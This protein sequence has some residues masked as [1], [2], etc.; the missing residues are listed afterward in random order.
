MSFNGE[1]LKIHTKRRE[2]KN[3]ACKNHE[4]CQDTYI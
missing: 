2:A 4:T 1:I 3:K